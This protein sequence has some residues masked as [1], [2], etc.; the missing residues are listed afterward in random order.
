MIEYTVYWRGFLMLTVQCTLR[1][2]L[3]E[4]SELSYVKIVM[5]ISDS[6]TYL[7]LQCKYGTRKLR[8][9]FSNQI[10]IIN[11]DYILVDTIHIAVSV[12]D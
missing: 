12:T 7:Y 8:I 10:F 6:D 9:L 11:I 4:I 1:N 2:I 5:R 3:I